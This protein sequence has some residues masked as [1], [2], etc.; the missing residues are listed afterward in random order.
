VTW[1]EFERLEKV[2]LGLGDA[3]EDL[4]SRIASDR[5]T[6]RSGRPLGTAEQKVMQKRA[7]RMAVAEERF[8]TALG[9]LC[10]F[11]AAHPELDD[12]MRAREVAERK[13]IYLEAQAQGRTITFRNTEVWV[14]PYRKRNFA[15][16][17]SG[18]R[19]EEPISLGDF[20][21]AL[22]DEVWVDPHTGAV[23][24]NDDDD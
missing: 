2:M 23:V 19:K 14:H 22:D 18:P 15:P 4:G 12:P 16:P 9:Q 6:V 3:F 8:M 7:G 24:P 11:C 21:T 13:R 5:E 10:D 20:L 1:R 17:D